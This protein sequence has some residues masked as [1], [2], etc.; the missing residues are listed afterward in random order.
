MLGKVIE[1]L[2]RPYPRLDM[3]I[4]KSSLIACG[5]VFLLFWIFQPFGIAQLPFK[6]KCIFIGAFTIISVIG[7]LCP[8][9][10][11]RFCFSKDYIEEENWVVW[12]VIVHYLLILIFIATGIWFM[13]MPLGISCGFFHLLLYVLGIGI[14]PIILIT[15][16]TERQ[17]LY[18]NLRE[19]EKLNSLLNGRTAGDGVSGN[20]TQ[21]GS[22]E[23]PA[24]TPKRNAAKKGNAAQGGE[25]RQPRKAVH[26][27]APEGNATMPDTKPE[28]E[29][30]QG[31]ET[32][33]N[34]KIILQDGTKESLGLAPEA[35]LYMKSELN[36]VNV[37]YLADGREEKRMIRST[38]KQA[39]SSC[40]DYPF[41]RRCHRTY[42]VN[43]RQ[44]ER[45]SG[46][47][48][49]YRARLSCCREEIPV[50]RQY[51]DSLK[52]QL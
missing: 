40:S 28:R 26:T 30:A 35:V 7:T 13:M 2:R 37:V 12:K 9:P 8:Y 5:V 45:I 36:Y 39:E 16:L 4:W 31:P 27:S 24:T 50:S 42:I 48:Q 22:T 44:I 46:N 38:L 29:A 34:G 6:F 3:K 51:A 33:P 18:R 15:F 52:S 23:L 11:Y 10:L 20:A 25:T 41:I 19:A 14:F 1:Y 47:S 49:G 43:V 32:A 17:S 21:D